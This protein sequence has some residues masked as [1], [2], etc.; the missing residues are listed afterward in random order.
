M[1]HVIKQHLLRAQTRMK[2][3]ED[4]KHSEVSFAVGEQVFLKL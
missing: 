3:Q 1:C 4:K 2:H